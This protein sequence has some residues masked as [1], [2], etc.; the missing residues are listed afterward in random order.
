MRSNLLRASF[1]GVLTLA[2]AP[3]G[4]LAS[5]KPYHPLAEQ[6]GRVVGTQLL[7]RIQGQA[8]SIENDA[9]EVSSLLR[10]P[11]A[12][13]WWQGDSD[14]YAQ[15]KSHVNRL[16]RLLSELGAEQAGASRAE[17]KVVREI[18]A[19]SYEMAI[20]TQDAIVTLGKDR[21]H[22]EL[23]D[24]P[25]LTRDISNEANR[26][27]QTICRFDKYTADRKQAQMLKSDLGLARA[28]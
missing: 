25:G 13:D 17:Q 18:A 15:M 26:V 8:I 24:L 23:S 27:D 19:P 9:D 1:V 12:S 2:L 16:N 5:P 28:A 21:G 6:Q 7:N 20:A 3:L 4:L 11:S 14:F 22:V 10:A